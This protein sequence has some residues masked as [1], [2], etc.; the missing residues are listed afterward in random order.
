MKFPIL[1]AYHRLESAACA[2][3]A[4]L[5]SLC[6]YPPDKYM[7]WPID[8]LQ[9]M[10]VWIINLW[11]L[12]IFNWFF[13]STNSMEIVKLH[14]LP[15]GAGLIFFYPLMYLLLLK[16]EWNRVG[17]WMW[18]IFDK[19]SLWRAICR[20][21]FLTVV[22]FLLSLFRLY[23]QELLCDLCLVKIFDFHSSSMMAGH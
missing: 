11:Q 15:L 1:Q 12:Y 9:K 8:E 7:C 2:S 17:K 6:T 21:G 10:C 18:W 3:P 22:F 20:W 16:L 13:P 4:P 5:S 23:F 19:E 14:M